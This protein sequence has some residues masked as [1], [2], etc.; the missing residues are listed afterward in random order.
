MSED[1]SRELQEHFDRGIVQDEDTAFLKGNM[2][3]GYK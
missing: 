3:Q 2:K 1:K